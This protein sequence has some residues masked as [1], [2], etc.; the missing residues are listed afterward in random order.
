MPILDN[1]RHERFAQGL[2]AGKSAAEAYTAAGYKGDRTAASRL[3]TNVNVQSRVTELQGKV[4]ERLTV[5]RQWVLDRLIENA[6]MHQ[7]TVP[8]ASN[9]ALEL[10]GKE[11]GMFVEHVENINHNYIISDTPIT[12]D[13]WSSEYA[14]TEH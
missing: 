11:M 4:V 2:A 10:I 3:S 9:K 12:D 13:E 8:A 14:P 6:T 5:D 7:A 1:A